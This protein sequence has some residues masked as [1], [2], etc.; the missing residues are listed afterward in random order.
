MLSQYENKV[1]ES[2]YLT[3]DIE[4]YIMEA[5][6]TSH[7]QLLEAKIKSAQEAVEQALEELRIADSDELVELWANRLK[8]RKTDLRRIQEAD[9][10]KIAA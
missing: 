6:E 3:V 8:Q 5:M 2:S 1:K 9:Q 10:E 7:E 4:K